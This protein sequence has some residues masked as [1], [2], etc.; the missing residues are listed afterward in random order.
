M[1]LDELDRFDAEHVVVSAALRSRKENGGFYSSDRDPADPGVAVYFQWGGRPR[2]IACDAYLTLAE[3]L[4]AVQETI[5]AMRAIGRH[6]ATGLLE[7]ALSG[8]TALPPGASDPSTPPPEDWWVTL[9]ISGIGGFSVQQIAS[10]RTNPMRS[11]LLKT[12]EAVY[13]AKVRET[14]PDRSRG[15]VDE[16]FRAEAEMRR[17]NAAIEAARNALK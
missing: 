8:F 9:Q 7:Q 6:G 10:D 16:M 3:N 14:H 13:R 17:L 11:V 12:A 4:R 5:K 2:T 15:K 1:L